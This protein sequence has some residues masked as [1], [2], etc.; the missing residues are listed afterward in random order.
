M[1]ASR[2]TG[3]ILLMKILKGDD[4]H[5]VKNVFIQFKLCLCNTMVVSLFIM[6]SRVEFFTL[7]NCPAIKAHAMSD[8]RRSARE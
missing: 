2:F 4:F 3:M 7:S 5:V 8:K 6:S 1:R